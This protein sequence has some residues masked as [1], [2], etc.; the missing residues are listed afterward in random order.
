[1]TDATA[2]TGVAKVAAPLP[3]PATATAP[4][5]A[6]PE[7]EEHIT[8]TEFCTVLSHTKPGVEA[9]AVFFHDETA[10]QRL[11][12]TATAYRARFKTVLSRPAK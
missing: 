8:L 2:D 5:P 3:V 1:M 7:P 4:A 9:I 10:S 11:H 6:A 12:D